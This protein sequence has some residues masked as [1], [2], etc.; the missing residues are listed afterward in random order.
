MTT[1]IEFENSIDGDTN[2][3]RLILF[4]LNILNLDIRS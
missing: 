2:P 3:A 4:P 1:V